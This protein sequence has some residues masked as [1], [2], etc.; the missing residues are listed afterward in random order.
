M[1][2]NFA[3]DGLFK[4]S[5][6]M[7]MFQEIIGAWTILQPHASQLS[8]SW[9]KTSNWRKPIGSYWRVMANWGSSWKCDRSWED[10]C[11]SGHP[12]HLLEELAQQ[13][14]VQ[15][16]GPNG[17]RFFL[18]M[19]ISLLGLPSAKKKTWRELRT[20]SNLACYAHESSRYL[21]KSK[22]HKL[23]YTI[24][25]MFL[26]PCPQTCIFT[27]DFWMVLTLA[28]LPTGS[29]TTGNND[30]PWWHNAKYPPCNSHIPPCLKVT[31]SSKWLFR[32]AMLVRRVSD[33]K[34]NTLKTW[35]FVTCRNSSGSI[36][37]DGCGASVQLLPGYNL[38]PLL[39]L[40]TIAATSPAS[41]Q[42]YES[43]MY[44]CCIPKPPSNTG[45]SR[46]S[47]A[48]KPMIP[49]DIPWSCW[50]VA[51]HTWQGFKVWW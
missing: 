6:F 30:E 1:S 44:K 16:H 17:W 15:V 46:A 37:R 47:L 49:I 38:S 7:L 12:V 50:H 21:W 48:W 32:V 18:Q 31:T 34:W 43:R 13:L 9:W 23:T 5:C 14:F 26:A 19:F 3:A 25:Q 39:P 33:L 10:F 40:A 29:I 41:N 27:T 35:N 28:S 8:R 4:C 20:P 51:S 36:L 11:I 45:V 42:G 22:V 24:I 2:Q